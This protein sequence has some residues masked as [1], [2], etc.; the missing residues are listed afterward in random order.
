[1]TLGGII[2][3]PFWD[4]DSFLLASG[5]AS[6]EVR[7]PGWK[8]NAKSTKPVGGV[9]IVLLGMILIIIQNKYN[10]EHSKINME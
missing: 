1:M 10:R 9:S 4:L 5:G 2:L 3:A 8:I 7:P 6:G